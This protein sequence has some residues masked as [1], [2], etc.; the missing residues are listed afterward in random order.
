MTSGI[1][2]LRRDKG[3]RMRRCRQGAHQGSG[4]AAALVQRKVYDGEGPARF[5]VPRQSLG[6]YAREEFGGEGHCHR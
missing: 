5:T 3:R 2:G 1:L 6:A 4:L